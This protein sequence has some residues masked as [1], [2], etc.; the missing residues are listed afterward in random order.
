W[1]DGR[2]RT[3]YELV[4]SDHHIY[5][6]DDLKAIIRRF[7]NITAPDK[8]ILTT[9]KDAVRLIKF[10]QELESWPFYVLPITPCFL[11]DEEAGFRDLIIKFITEF[12]K[13]EE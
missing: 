3:Y 8:L 6:I 10:R 5:S 11:F 9:E 12:P 7:D 1:L 13:N 2:S 4:Y